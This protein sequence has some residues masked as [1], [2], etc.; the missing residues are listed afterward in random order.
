MQKLKMRVAMLG[1]ASLV[2]IKTEKND[3]SEKSLQLEKSKNTDEPKQ[4]VAYAQV[5]VAVGGAI[6]LAFVGAYWWIT[7]PDADKEALTDYVVRKV[8]DAGDNINKAKDALFKGIEDLKNPQIREQIIA[9]SRIV[10]TNRNKK[11]DPPPPNPPIPNDKG[12]GESCSILVNGWTYNANIP[13]PAEIMA[14]K[15]TITG[16]ASPYSGAL[17]KT[18]LSTIPSKQGAPLREV[19]NGGSVLEL[20]P[21]SSYQSVDT[22]G[23]CV[24]QLKTVKAMPTIRKE[25]SVDIT[26]INGGA[27]VD[28]KP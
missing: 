23:T 14:I 20:Y 18:T 24:F 28:Y 7:T 12:G 15:A 9:K 4:V 25:G 21:T 11:Q 3:V 6:A 1:S 17:L 27:R 22:T 19:P 2:G 16:R 5:V 8:Q 13:H 10:P 26:P